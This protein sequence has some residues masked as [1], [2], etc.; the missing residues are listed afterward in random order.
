MLSDYH[1]SWK[2]TIMKE[3]NNSNQSFNPTHL[4]SQKQEEFTNSNQ[5]FS[6]SI[7]GQVN[8]LNDK[9]FIPQINYTNSNRR[10]DYKNQLQMDVN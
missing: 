1:P 5:S 3:M 4:S 7:R 6:G 8:W 10:G 2:P 9:Y